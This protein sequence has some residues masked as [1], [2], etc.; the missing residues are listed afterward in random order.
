M[1]PTVLSIHSTCFKALRLVSVLML[2][3]VAGTWSLPGISA[4]TFAQRILG[5][6]QIAFPTKIQWP[7]QRGVNKYRLQIAEDERFSSI[8]YDGPV[9]GERYVVTGL[10]PG[11]YYWRIAPA[12]SQTGAFM[13]PVRFFIP[14]GVV[15]SGMP[16]ANPVTRPRVQTTSKVR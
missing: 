3:A 16:P 14:G 11:Y 13:R 1:F 10:A 2:C 4:R 7:K 6:R 8:F 12:G 9:S 5:Q 15:L